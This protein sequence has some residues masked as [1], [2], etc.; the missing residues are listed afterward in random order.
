MSTPNN[1][2]IEDLSI[3]YSNLNEKRIHAQSDLK[4]AEDHLKKLKDHAMTTWETDDLT[5]L[6][7]MLKEMRES[8]ERKRREYQEHLD[9]IELKLS[10]IDENDPIAGS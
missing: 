6:E 8:N 4:H 2:S 7:N 10:Q 1:Q 5:K 3:R 9:E